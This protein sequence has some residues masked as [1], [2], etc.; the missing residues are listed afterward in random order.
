MGIFGSHFFRAAG[1]IFFLTP[2]FFFGYLFFLKKNS[3]WGDTP[4]HGIGNRLG[5]R[6]WYRSPGGT[7]PPPP[8]AQTLFGSLPPFSAVLGPFG[9]FLAFWR[10]LDGQNGGKI[11][12]PTRIC[13]SRGLKWRLFWALL[14][15]AAYTIPLAPADFL[16]HDGG[17]PPAPFYSMTITKPAPGGCQVRGWGHKKEKVKREREREDEEKT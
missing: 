16:Y 8:P 15:T 7:P 2:K 11:E 9:P 3:A 4:T 13:R 5:P 10:F 6:V 14:G 1:P 12:R 17:Y